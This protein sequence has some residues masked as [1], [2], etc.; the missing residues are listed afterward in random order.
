LEQALFETQ[1]D[2]VDQAAP[3]VPSECQTLA[4]INGG[5]GVENEHFVRPRRNGRAFSRLVFFVGNNCVCS[6]IDVVSFSHDASIP[7]SYVSLTI[8]KSSIPP[9]DMLRVRANVVQ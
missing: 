4:C 2:T 7:A 5:F 6:Q 9:P 8:A 3:A 1:V